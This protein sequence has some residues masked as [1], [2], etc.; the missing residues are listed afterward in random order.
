M[1]IHRKYCQ[2]CQYFWFK[3]KRRAFQYFLQGLKNPQW[4][5]M[6]CLARVRFFRSIGIYF[7][8]HP[9]Q[10]DKDVD[11]IFEE[12]DADLAVE[13]LRSE[14]LYEG[15]NLPRDRLLE[16]QDFSQSVSYLGNDK[17]EL[18]FFLH[19]KDEAELKYQQKFVTA[20]HLNPAQ[21][22]QAV[23]KIAE[24]PKIWQIAAKYLETKPIMIETRL[25][26]TFV[27]EEAVSKSLS[28]PYNFH[29]D[30]ED[31]R[32]IKFM[33]YLNDVDKYS[34]SHVCVKGSHNRKKLSNQLSLIRETSDRQIFDYYGTEKVQ[35]I[36]GK[37]GLG[38]VEDFYCFHRG[39][40]PISQDRL[41]L[42]VKFAMNSY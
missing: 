20:H 10:L 17:Q 1:N 12:V 28:L 19:E 29:Y 13:R 32:F 27:L 16:I 33:F 9:Y 31:Y 11:S 35:T 24:D 39:T 23:Q 8:K 4:I 21:K 5:L 40:L 14:G 37:A 34:G 36:C 2:Y 41:I 25:W 18:S 22:C 42:E 3:F 26:W 6:F 38:F 30:L 15:I 7:S